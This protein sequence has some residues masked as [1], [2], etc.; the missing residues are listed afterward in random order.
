MQAQ[1]QVSKELDLCLNDFLETF[2]KKVQEYSISFML[3]S[4]KT[5]GSTLTQ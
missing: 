3:S 5:T 2:Q 4:N 1:L